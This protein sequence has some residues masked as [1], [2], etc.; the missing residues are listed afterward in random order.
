[1][2]YQHAFFIHETDQLHK[3][4]LFVRGNVLQLHRITDGKPDRQQILNFLCRIGFYCRLRSGNSAASL[5]AGNAFL[6][7]QSVFTKAVDLSLR[8]DH[9]SLAQ[10]QVAMFI[11][12][13]PYQRT[14][15][16]NFGKFD[17]LQVIFHTPDPSLFRP[18][19]ARALP[20]HTSI[21]N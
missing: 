6:A 12:H 15:D 8:F 20:G 17:W 9:R 16:L 19:Q 13:R 10:Q 14:A 3:I 18:A 2:R 21:H 1:M 7:K 11:E 5:T 4:T